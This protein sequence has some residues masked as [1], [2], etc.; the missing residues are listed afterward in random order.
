MMGN[1]IASAAEAAGKGIGKAVQYKGQQRA[2]EAASD[3]N[4]DTQEE[5]NKRYTEQQAGLK[6]NYGS[7]IDSGSNATDNL[8]DYRMREADPYV[9]SEFQGVDMDADPGVQYRMNQA[10]QSMDASAAQKGGLF[11]GAYA[12]A[13]QSNSQDLAS[14]EYQ[15]AYNRDYDKYS[16]M[17]AANQAQHN[18]EADR[19]YNYDNAYMQNQQQLAANGL[20]AT[21]TYSGLQNQN[22][23]TNNN[24]YMTLQGALADTT[25]VSTSTP[26]MMAGSVIG[27]AGQSGS[28]VSQYYMNSKQP[29]ASQSTQKAG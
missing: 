10:Q 23:N 21:N 13:L 20:N 11:S 15:N 22:Y 4:Q 7:Y 6:D 26:Y 27:S 2:A 12:K 8:E 16:D 29:S 24:N 17:E 9:R 14:Q 3:I 28:D 18:T 5:L 1:W 25:A 19:M